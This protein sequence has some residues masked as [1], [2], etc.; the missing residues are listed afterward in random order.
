MRILVFVFAALMF[1]AP[2]RGADDLVRQAID[3]ARQSLADIDTELKNPDLSQADL[4]R[5]RALNDPLG[6]KIQAVISELAPRLEAS[7]KR[8]AEL[9]PQLKDATDAAGGNDAPTAELKDEQARFASLDTDL[10]SARALLLQTDETASRIGAARR[11]LFAHETFARSSSVFSPFLWMALASEAPIDVSEI[12]GLVSGSTRDLDL[13]LNRS[14]TVGFLAFLAAL[15]ALA[16]PARWLATRVIARDPKVESPTRLKRAIAASW[17]TAVLVALPLGALGAISYAL[18]I[19]DISDPRMQPGVDAVLDGLRLIALAYAFG[20]GLLAPGESNWRLLALRDRTARV[21]FRFLMTT[22][23]LWASQK[24][25]EA[26]AEGTASLNVSIASRATCALLIGVAGAVTVRRVVDPTEKTRDPWG[27]ARTLAWVFLATLIGATIA[28]YIAFAAFLINQALF[29][30]GVGGAL[31]MLDA[32]I[33]E[34]AEQFLKPDTAL[35]HSLMTIIGLRRETVEQVVVV[36]Q[37]FARVAAT[38]T[39]VVVAFGPLGLPSQNFA[40]TLRA[41]YFG[42]AIG[43]LTIS[44]SSLLAAGIVFIIVILITR[45]AQNW[46]TDRYLP[47]TR[48]DPS[49]GNSLRTITGYI[50][51]V[52]ALLIG[53]TRLGL[54]LQKF[55][56]IAGALSVG[57]GFGLQSIVNNF[58]SGLILLWERSI[59]VGDWVVVGGE[60]GFVSKINARSTEIET[61]ERATL[62]VPNSTLV[63]TSVKN[64]LRADRVQRLVIGLNVEF[65]SDTEKVRE[66]MIAS[67]KA[68]EAVLTI[69]APLALFSEIADW[70]LKFQLICFVDDGLMTERV[71]S[72]INF[73]LY[74][75]LEEAGIRLARPYPTPK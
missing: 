73:D 64:W 5:L 24:L 28:G 21:L 3:S 60:Q 6:L 11:E 31:Y 12:A 55:G 36:V 74:R 19:F 53:G 71:R 16:W 40:A 23:F 35:G 52:V 9:K 62:I 4:A 41:A 51:L 61:F 56:L 45:A 14:E 57:I 22:A 26:I 33:Q 8:L 48:L 69:P 29:V 43:G 42:Y 59:R 65:D 15:L 58:V 49:V 44:L 66:L 13:R 39:A 70:S 47:R 30:F 7:R 10:R 27:P 37:A 63:T 20:K 32:V 50:G 2:L 18:D 72:E 46:L 68:Q 38:A 1:A 34:S 67:A 75:K 17:T 54:D 25:F